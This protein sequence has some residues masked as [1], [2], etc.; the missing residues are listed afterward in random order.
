MFRCCRF[1]SL[2]FLILLCFIAL[3]PTSYAASL[4][5]VYTDTADVDI[6]MLPLASVADVVPFATTPGIA[7]TVSASSLSTNSI[8]YDNPGNVL[9]AGWFGTMSVTIPV[10]TTTQT[11]TSPYFDSFPFG[12]PTSSGASRVVSVSRSYSH[13][14]QGSTRYTG[15]GLYSGLMPVEVGDSLSTVGQDTDAILYLNLPAGTYSYQFSGSIT[16][17]NTV[18]GTSVQ[19]T[20]QLS[21]DIFSSVDEI[22]T[23][24]IPVRIP[25]AY[26]ST[27]ATSGTVNASVSF[28]LSRLNIYI[29]KT[30]LTV[31]M[32]LPYGYYVDQNGSFILGSNVPAYTYLSQGLAGI[33]KDLMGYNGTISSAIYPGYSDAMNYSFSSLGDILSVLTSQLTLDLTWNGLYLN[34]GGVQDNLANYTSGRY[35]LTEMIRAGFL[36]IASISREM[37]G[38][39]NNMYATMRASSGR[40]SSYINSSGQLTTLSVSNMSMSDLLSYVITNEA[41]GFNHLASIL[42]GTYGSSISASYLDFDDNLNPSI[43]SVRYTNV[44]QAMADGFSRIQNPL[45]QLQAVLANDDDLKLRQETQPQV[46]AVTDSFLGNSSA[47]PSTDDIGDVAGVSGSIS[48][49]FDSGVSSSDFFSSVTSSDSYSFFSQEVANDLDSSGAPAAIAAD[50][51]DIEPDLSDYQLGDDGFYSLSDSSFFDLQSFL[52]GR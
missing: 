27:T 9:Y 40:S 23:C 38:T 20:Q 37:Q 47:A 51:G 30:E 33:A 5:G 10:G 25:S 46:D 31:L 52:E 24:A 17:T 15:R 48:G 13:V 50:V 36:G 44:L 41:D 8:V 43:T 19:S 49:M 4:D 21:Q 42:R 18:N 14:S 11:V 22:T 45:S 32:M 29:N 35:P 6:L 7:T 16:V 12:S 1:F 2:S 39:M 3:L 34:E 26:L 28:D